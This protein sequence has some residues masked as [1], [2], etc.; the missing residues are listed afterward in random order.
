MLSTYRALAGAQNQP[1]L[2]VPPGGTNFQIRDPTEG[3]H[4][5]YDALTS[6]KNPRLLPASSYALAIGVQAFCLGGAAIFTAPELS[7]PWTYRGSLYNQLA[8]EPQVGVWCWQGR[9]PVFLCQAS[10][11][12]SCV[13]VRGQPEH[14]DS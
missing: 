1:S 3:R 6:S 11:A 4:A 8:P 5:I 13:H 12:N 7:G 9:M 10:T 2:Q 14:T